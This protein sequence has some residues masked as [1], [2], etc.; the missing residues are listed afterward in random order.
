[1]GGVCWLLP[2]LSALMK[3]GDV[4]CPLAALVPKPGWLMA[5]TGACWSVAVPLALVDASVPVQAVQVGSSFQL[6]TFC[7]GKLCLHLAGG[8]TEGAT[9]GP[10]GSHRF[11]F[12]SHPCLHL[13]GSPQLCPARGGLG[14]D[15]RSPPPMDTPRRFSSCLCWS[16]QML[17]EP[18]LFPRDKLQLR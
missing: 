10:M 3:A 7:S 5:T 17:A 15:P 9:R 8:R 1:M 2:G 11:W 6:E 18:L 14:W 16:C 13:G 12:H 4:N